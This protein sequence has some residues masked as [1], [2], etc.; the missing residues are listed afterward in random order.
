MENYFDVP[1]ILGGQEPG[2]KIIE[3]SFVVVTSCCVIVKHR[4]E[5]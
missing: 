4:T 1:K 2:V 5:Y 3:E